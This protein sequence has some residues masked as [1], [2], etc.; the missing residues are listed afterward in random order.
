MNHNEMFAK[1]QEKYYKTNNK[2]VLVSKE[3][4]LKDT[5]RTYD[6]ILCM[7]CS[8]MDICSELY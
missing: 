6:S 8:P 2:K 5:D 1:L 7:T 3:I 4:M